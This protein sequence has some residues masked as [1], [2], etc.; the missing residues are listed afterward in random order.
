M[1][2]NVSALRSCPSRQRSTYLVNLLQ[3]HC[4]RAEHECS[5]SV[6]ST[7]CGGTLSEVSQHSNCPTAGTLSHS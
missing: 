4:S 3:T 6:K 5:R 7:A 1:H 2:E